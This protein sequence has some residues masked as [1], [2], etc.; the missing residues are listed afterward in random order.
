[1][2]KREEEKRENKKRQR[3]ERET[4]LLV[5]QFFFETK[6]LFLNCVCGS[7][8]A[9]DIVSSYSISAISVFLY[10]AG[11]KKC[12]HP[13]VITFFS[14][15]RQD[16]TLNSSKF[17]KSSSL[18]SLQFVRAGVCLFLHLFFG[19]KSRTKTSRRYIY[20]YRE[21][22]IKRERERDL[23]LRKVT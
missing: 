4:N 1:V 19:S 8:C 12:P 9:I 17:K 14:T 23:F 15:I 5:L 16:E 10:A 20:I 18:F 7:C 3:A 11:E 13:H 2:G 22:E 6:L 21:R